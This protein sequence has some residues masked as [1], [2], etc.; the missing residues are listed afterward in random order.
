MLLGDIIQ[1]HYETF[2]DSTCSA[3]EGL[4]APESVAA[5]LRMDALER[6]RAFDLSTSGHK[7]FITARD[8]DVAAFEQADWLTF[9]ETGLAAKVAAGETSYYKKPIPPEV[10]SFYQCLLQYAHAEIRSEE[11]RVGK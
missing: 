10:Q 1:K 2:L 4:K 11:R 6:L 3:W 5:A 7:N 9:I 8:K